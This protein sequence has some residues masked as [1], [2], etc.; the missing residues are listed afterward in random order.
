MRRPSSTT[1]NV[2]G[3]IVGVATLL[4]LVDGK[5]I[6]DYK[7]D[8]RWPIGW[9][10]AKWLRYPTATL[11]LRGL[12]VN[13]SGSPLGV[14]LSQHSNVAAR[15]LSTMIDIASLAIG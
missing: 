4:P 10:V 12:A 2:K 5:L 1:S 14:H 15:S 7:A 9:P 13:T 8:G 6:A 11:K 3:C